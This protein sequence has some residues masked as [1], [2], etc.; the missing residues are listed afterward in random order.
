M[1]R[2]NKF[3]LAHHTENSMAIKLNM[4]PEGHT[5][6]SS[7]H[8][9]SLSLSLLHARLRIL[10]KPLHVLNKCSIA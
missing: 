8:F 1:P 4:E 5:H 3:E 2:L 9:V 7:Y 6:P 10:L